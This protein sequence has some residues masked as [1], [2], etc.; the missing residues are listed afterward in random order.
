MYT[1]D[2]K[3]NIYTSNAATINQY[4]Y[5]YTTTVKTTKLFEILVFGTLSHISGVF[6]Y[7][8]DYLK[9]MNIFIIKW[10]KNS[11]VNDVEWY[12]QWFCENNDEVVWLCLTGSA[13]YLLR[14]L[15]CLFV[16]MIE[17]T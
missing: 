14:K 8:I 1:D 12:K 2:Q 17:N 5:M 9:L 15:D 11:V 16:Y 7:C 4:L 10:V 13:L 3:P 6:V